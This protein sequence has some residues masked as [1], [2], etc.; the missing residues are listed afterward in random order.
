MEIRTVEACFNPENLEYYNYSNCH[1]VVVDV[2]RATSAICAAFANGANSIIPIPTVE[3]A[4]EAKKKGYMVAAERNGITLDFADFGNS[5][6]NFTPERIGGKDVAYST[7]NGTQ[8]IVKASGGLSVAIGSFLNLNSVAKWLN[9][10]EQGN[11]LILCAGWKGR[12]CLEDTLFA[13]ALSEILINSYSYTSISDSVQASLQLWNTAKTD[14]FSYLEL[15]AQRHRLKKMGLD[16]VLEYCFTPNSTSKVPE[17]ANG[18]LV[19]LD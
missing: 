11:A 7:T 6:F 17:L 13:G 10:K 18:R 9:A 19:V 12:F 3:E 14:L 16:D 1:I 8:A 2:L 15:I 5:P 4:R